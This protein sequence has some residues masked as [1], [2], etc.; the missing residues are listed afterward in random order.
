MLAVSQDENR[1][2]NALPV[3]TLS[4]VIGI[5]GACFASANDQP[6]LVGHWE[7]DSNLAASVP[8]IVSAKFTRLAS[9]TAST[10]SEEHCSG[11]QITIVATLK[12][13]AS[14]SYNVTYYLRVG[15]WTQAPNWEEAQPKLGTRYILFMRSESNGYFIEKI[16][17]LNDENLAKIRT[18]IAA[19]PNH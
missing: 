2:K 4:V 16:V 11:G 19:L 14:G 8:D 18:L 3:F 9:P 1:M 5:V 17:P 13:T 12:G 6:I 10:M 15:K 7:K